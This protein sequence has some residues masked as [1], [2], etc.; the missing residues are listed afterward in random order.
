MDNLK[1]TLKLI[2]INFLV[3]FVL[4]IIA[5]LV[6]I[7][8]YKGYKNTNEYKD[9]RAKLANYE[10]IEWSD[11]HFEELREISAEYQSYIG[12]RMQKFSGQTISIDE[13]GVR[14]TPQHHKVDKKSN[15]VVFLGGSTT[16]GVGTNDSTTIPA[17]FSQIAE[18][19]FET[20][21]YGEHS[22]RAFQSYLFFMSKLN[23]GLAPDIV[24]SY[25]G[26]N[27]KAGFNINHKPSSHSREE[28][29]RN[30]MKGQDANLEEQKAMSF[31][32]FLF[33][34]I[35]VLIAKLKK[36]NPSA[37]TKNEDEN[38]DQRSEEVAKAMLDAW[39]ASKFIS[40][41]NGALFFCVLQPNALIGS[42]NLEHL[43]INPEREEMYKKLYSMVFK[44]LK[45]PQ[46][47]E[48]SNNFIDLTHVLDGE[49]QY[50]I[51]F[52]HLSPNGNK[53]IADSLYL[54]IDKR[55]TELTK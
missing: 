31:T 21:N 52:C 34:P 19:K 7:L 38:K 24:I 18:G 33:G 22:Y 26:V 20:V 39:M 29:I 28:Q 27:E 8:I 11:Q 45:T 13:Q 6:A 49:D 2:M 40:E 4:I 41:K 17:F 53:V 37:A 15:K 9:S 36:N 54:K 10:D 1:K 46:Y 23:E 44:L 43:N 3:L 51:D 55:I 30:V 50:Y 14:Q 35:K 48:L 5:N 12:W 32:H 47:S 16:W 25:D 42:P